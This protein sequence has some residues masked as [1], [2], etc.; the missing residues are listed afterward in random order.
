MDSGD[1]GEIYLA[2]ELAEESGGFSCQTN[3]VEP[4]PWTLIVGLILGILIVI[5]ERRNRC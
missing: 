3:Q 4:E 1:T 5:C 2:S